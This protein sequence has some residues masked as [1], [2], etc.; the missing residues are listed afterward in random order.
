MADIQ[1]HIQG[2]EFAAC[3]CDWGCPCQF[4]GRPSR[5][6]C[7]AVVGMRIEDGEFD[8]VRLDGLCWVGT[9]SWP[10]AI[11]EGNGS[12][13]VFIEQ[14]AS[15]AQQNAL[16]TILS[17]GETDPGA[18][19]FQVFSTTISE[20]HEP[21]RVPIDFAADIER[22]TGHVRIAGIVESQGEPI[23]NPITGEEHRARLCLPNGFEYYEAE[24]GNSSFSATGNVAISSPGGHAHFARLHLN[25][26]G[27]VH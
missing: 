1:W 16:L 8:G 13:Q 9:F 3:N 6:N 23:R 24:F 5:G 26:H 18:T 21:R 25:R 20:M 2:V 11:H 27:V 12:A 4:N 10:G 17:G 19:I 15:E 7:N 14:H 22:R